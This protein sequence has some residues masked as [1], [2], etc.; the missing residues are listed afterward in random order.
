MKILSI[1]PLI[2]IITANAAPPPKGKKIEFDFNQDDRQDSSSLIKNQITETEKKHKSKPKM[3]HSNF[4]FHSKRNLPAYYLE[5]KPTRS[6]SE[7]VLDSEKTKVRSN[8]INIGDILYASIEQE[9]VASPGVPTP[10]RAFILSEKGKGS[11][12]LGEA[13]LDRELKRILITFN[14]Y[15]DKNLKI[16]EFK[17]IALSMSG[18]IGLIGEY[19]TQ[20]GKFFIGELASI[21]AAGFVDSTIQRQQTQVGGYVQEPSL[22]NST[23]NAAV[24]A[25]S[26]TADRMAE[27]SRNAP[28]YTVSQSHQLIKV[29]VT[30]SL[31]EI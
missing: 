5:T 21:A 24:Q 13:I 25:L 26:R 7:V 12:I 10:V 29:I 30:E 1:F 28:E 2:V 17:A 11:F 8:L 16:Y 15:R 23:K 3:T 31:I 20:A 18:S 19:H 4:D 9:I 14:R 6:F 22:S 27:N